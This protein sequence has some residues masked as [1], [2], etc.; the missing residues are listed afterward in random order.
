[1]CGI[2]GLVWK[3]REARR[4]DD[5]R[6]AAAL[7]VHRGPDGHGEFIDDR[8]MLIHY[9]LA[10]LDLSP[11]GHQPFE[12][13]DEH[14]GV[15]VYNGE[16][17]NFREIAA[18]R[19]IEQKTTCDTEIVLKGVARF[20]PDSLSEY[21]GIFALAQYFPR[22]GSLL[23][24]RDRLGVK[25][26]YFLDTPEYFAFASEAKVLYAFMQTLPL[27]PVVLRE[28]LSYGSSMSCE[29][30]VSGVNKLPPGSSLLLNLDN[31]QTEAR[32]FWSVARLADQPPSDLD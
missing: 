3:T 15:G 30:I 21:N 17:Y 16:L 6:A 12:L 20:G 24:A 31:F 23:L 18:S 32:S 1:M 5:F 7:M 8:L 22:E 26:L 9:R 27:N 19:G 14:E 28:F 11:A 25:P 10:I 29:T 4:I 2:A 13:R